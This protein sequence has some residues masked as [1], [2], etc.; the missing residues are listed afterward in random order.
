MMLNALLILI[1]IRPF[2]SSMAFPALNLAY[3][4]LLL[5]NL[6][7]IIW[8]HHLKSI[9]V[10]VPGTLIGARHRYIRNILSP[11]T[12]FILALIISL[13]FSFNKLTS[14][15]E[16]YKYITGILLL[17][18]AFKLSSEEKSKMIRVIIFAGF[19]ISILALYQYFFGFRHTMDYVNKIHTTDPFVL[20]YLNRKRIFF[21]FVMPNALAGYLILII[22]LIFAEKNKDK[23]IIAACMLYALFLTKSLGAIISLFIATALYVYLKRGL[24]FTKII[25]FVILAAMGAVIFIIRQKNSAQHTLP[26]FSLIQRLGYWHDTLEIIKAHPLTG[27]GMGN[28]NIMNSRYAHNSY[29]Q[30][31]AEAGIL[32]LISFLWLV[33]ATLK[34]NHATIKI[35]VFAFLIHNFVDFTFF[36]PEVSFIWWLTL[37]LIY[38]DLTKSITPSSF[39]NPSL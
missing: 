9:F 39:V 37:G 11:L 38:N 18:T 35:A 33:W 4:Y 36:L 14:L 7:I 29:L 31:W 17:I 23:W 28:F 24:S 12:L 6:I 13:F 15:Q 10:A 20:D 27:V 26:S 3:S 1:F 34:H 19:I 5:I 30:L 25:P 8:K 21:P 22:P 32:S 2:I 16:L